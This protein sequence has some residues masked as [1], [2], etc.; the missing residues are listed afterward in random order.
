MDKYKEFLAANVL[1]EDKVVDFRL[2]SRALKVHVNLAKQMLFEFHRTQNAKKPGTVQATY[3]ICGTKPAAPSPSQKTNGVHHQN[4]EDTVMQSSS[5][6]S[7]MPEP[8]QDPEAEPEQLAITTIALV[9]EEDLEDMKA[10]FQKITSIYVHSLQSSR[11][12]N[13]Y[14]LS[15]C[16]R[17]LQDKYGNE[18]PLQT[19]KQYGIIQNTNVK[20]R[21]GKRPAGVVVSTGAPPQAA[22]KSTG[23]LKA[24]A[25]Q[26]RPSEAAARAGISGEGVVRKQAGAHAAPVSDLSTSKPEPP[27]LKREKSNLFKAFT[28]AKEKKKPE[29][30]EEPSQDTSM[31]DA[32]EEE[33]TGD[34]VP[35]SNADADEAHRKARAERAAKLKQMMEDDG[36]SLTHEFVTLCS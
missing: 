27:S 8:D 9:Q 18:D 19:W 17:E 35:L 31:D 5:L 36:N 14:V 4:G 26:P 16:T 29:K 32:D 34:L 28:K 6:V 7:S 23:S 1:N 21:T 11:L 33:D 2:L 12:E 15:D 30:Q 3:I 20:R 13:V 24:A 22:P 10:Q 25:D